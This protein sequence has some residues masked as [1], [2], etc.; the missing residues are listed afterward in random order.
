MINTTNSKSFF[1]TKNKNYFKEETDDINTHK[2]HS[3]N[4]IQTDL[5]RKWLTVNS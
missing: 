5:S 1:V 3:V 2:R 4:N